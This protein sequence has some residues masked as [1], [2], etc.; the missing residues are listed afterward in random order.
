MNLLR[1][2]P[3]RSALF[4]EFQATLAAYTASPRAA[5]IS[6]AELMLLGAAGELLRFCVIYNRVCKHSIHI[7][8]PTLQVRFR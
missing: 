6:A 5:V 2:P 3:I 4:I 7:L 1:L 8:V